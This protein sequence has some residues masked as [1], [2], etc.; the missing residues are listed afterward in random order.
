MTLDRPETVAGLM[1]EASPTT[2]GGHRGLEGFVRD[3]ADLADPIDLDFART[4]TGSR[5]LCRLLVTGLAF[6]PVRSRCES[7]SASPGA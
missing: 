5:N 4:L 3:V 1:L 2:L 7:V 6:R